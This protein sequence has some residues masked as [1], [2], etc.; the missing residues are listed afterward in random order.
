MTLDCFPFNFLSMVHRII[1]RIVVVPIPNSSNQLPYILTII[2]ACVGWM[3]NWREKK[4][5]G[6]RRA[7]SGKY[8]NK[9]CV[10]IRQ[11]IRIRSV[12]LPFFELL[13]YI[14]SGSKQSLTDPCSCY[15]RWIDLKEPAWFHFL[16]YFFL[17]FPHAMLPYLSLFSLTRWAS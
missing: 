16:F 11:C 17:L 15:S 12:D 3:Q 13:C 9:R 8:I 2:L 5:E 14:D 4:E 7:A 1:E 10:Y 6:K